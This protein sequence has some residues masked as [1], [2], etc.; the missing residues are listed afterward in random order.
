MS[1]IERLSGRVEA[2]KVVLSVVLDHLTL[3]PLTR[4]EVA[5]D[6][7]SASSAARTNPEGILRNRKALDGFVD[8]LDNTLSAVLKEEL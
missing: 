3:D 2:L 5:Q 4:R 7:M 8:E 1:D 6:I